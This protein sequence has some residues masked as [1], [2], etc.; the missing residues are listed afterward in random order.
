MEK[1]E[2]IAEGNWESIL[3]S[4]GLDPAFFAYKEGPCPVCGGNTRF[5]W[6]AKQE[7]GFCNH[8]RLLGGFKLL[9]HL[10]G[11]EFRGA[12][13]YIRAWH[14]GSAKEM[15]VNAQVRTVKKTEV[16][17][18]EKLWNKYDV[19]WCEGLPVT[20]GD[21]VHKYV[22]GRVDLQNIPHVLRYQPRMP[23]WKNDNGAFVKVGEYPAMLALVQGHDGD[24]VNVWRTYITEE[25]KKASFEDAKKAAGR[26]LGTSQAVRLVEP[27]DELGIAEGIETALAVWKMYG[28]PCWSTLNADGM[29]KFELPQGYEDVTK[30]RIFGDN[31]RKDS[32]GKRAGNDAAEFLKE[33]I[34]AQGKACTIILPKFTDFDFADLSK[35]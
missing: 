14:G 13:D 31:D 5:R 33:K 27:R 6:R 22:Q 24:L 12:A 28:I 20:T 30:V 29:K 35:K 4:A 19:M 34:R 23:Y 16:D 26:F 9:Q 2:D 15:P 1:A 8:C 10:L 7:S 11:V 17:D 18:T 3:L 32:N 21:P 25:G